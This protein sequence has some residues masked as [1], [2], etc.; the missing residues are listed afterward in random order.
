MRKKS[1][2]NRQLGLFAAICMLLDGLAPDWKREV[3]EDC[4]E[5]YEVLWGMFRTKIPRASE[6]LERYQGPDFQVYMAGEPVLV[7]ELAQNLQ[8]NMRR[9][10]LLS[11]VG[12]AGLLW[13]ARPAPHR[14]PAAPVGRPFG[15]ETRAFVPAPLRGLIAQSTPLRGLRPRPNAAG[16]SGLLPGGCPPDVVDV[17]ELPVPDVQPP[18]ADHGVGPRVAFAALG[19]LEL[20]DDLEALRVRPH[21]RH[22]AAIAHQIARSLVRLPLP[23]H[24]G[25]NSPFD[26][27]G[28]PKVVPVAVTAN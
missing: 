15:P 10:V 9:F 14:G 20:A 12:I 28:L 5:P 21:Q 6:V 3:E 26:Y 19:Q 1:F 25:A 23:I 11:V 4:A 27:A 22:F 7:D 13:V 24:I 17:Q 16:P 18:A 2:V 8:K